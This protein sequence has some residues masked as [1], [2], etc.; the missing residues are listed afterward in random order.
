VIVTVSNDYHLHALMNGLKGRFVYYWFSPAQRDGFDE[1]S[2]PALPARSLRLIV[3]RVHLPPDRSGREVEFW[4]NTHLHRHYA[5]WVGEGYEV[6]SYLY[7]PE[8]MP[9]REVEYR[10][11]A[12]MTMSAVGMTPLV[13]AP[14][15]P[16]WLE[17]H[18]GARKRP[19][20]DFDIF[21]QFLD[22]D[23]HFIN[24]TDGPPQFGAAPTSSWRPGDTVVD[25]R[26]FY[27]PEGARPG[28]Y[29]VIAGFYRKGKRN[30]V[31]DGSGQKLGTHIELG[32]VEV[33]GE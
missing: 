22:S 17:F 19:R 28:K 30:P 14:G 33:V 11:A 16:V 3:D 6:Y 20:N 26:A 32:Q 13:I 24:G 15:E 1:L 10:W 18:C 8:E 25:R 2:Q 29:Q 5:E 12:R 4:L 9:L 27:V 7:P 31:S 21:V 23:G